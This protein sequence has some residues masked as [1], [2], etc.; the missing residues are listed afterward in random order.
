MYD[1]PAIW[2]GG[3]LTEDARFTGSVIEFR[4]DQKRDARAALAEPG[5]PAPLK[6]G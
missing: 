4:R 2:M 6:Y 3:S 5:C 1:K